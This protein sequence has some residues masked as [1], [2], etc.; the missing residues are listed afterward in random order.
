MA[1]RLQG[2]LC[3]HQNLSWIPITQGKLD[4][5]VHTCNSNVCGMEETGRY[6]GFYAVSVSKTVISRFCERL[7]LQN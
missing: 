7:C 2:L 1:E 6:Q 4:V 5:M 3:K